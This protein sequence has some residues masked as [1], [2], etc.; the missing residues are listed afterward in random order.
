M[1]VNIAQAIAAYSNAPK[2]LDAASGG[3]PIA[4]FSDILGAALTE[5]AGATQKAEQAMQ[6]GAGGQAN[7]VDVVTAVANAEVT[8]ETVV[9]LRDRVIGAYQEIMRMPI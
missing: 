5:T 9:A 6:M 8:L 2:P 4:A 3:E 1:A 7:L